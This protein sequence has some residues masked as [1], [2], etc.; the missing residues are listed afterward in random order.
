MYVCVCANT[1]QMNSDTK[2]VLFSPI[3]DSSR[4]DAQMLVFDL[5]CNRIT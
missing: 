1:T 2:S 5:H 3:L 4:L